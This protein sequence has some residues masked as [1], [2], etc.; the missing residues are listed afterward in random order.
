VW[1][2]TNAGRYTG[3]ASSGVPPPDAGGRLSRY[4]SVSATAPR[5]ASAASS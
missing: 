3:I 2:A 4:A 1:R 5:T